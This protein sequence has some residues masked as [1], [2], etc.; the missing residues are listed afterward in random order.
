MNKSVKISFWAALGKTVGVFMSAGA[1][2]LM[3]QLIGS[4][5]IAAISVASALA[6]TG[7]LLIWFAENERE[8]N[9]QE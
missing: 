9:R 3:Y 2:S 6:I 8:R 1:G 7:F 5:H 4:R